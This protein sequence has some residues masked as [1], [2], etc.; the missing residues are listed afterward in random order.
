M[1][2]AI[3]FTNRSNISSK[4]SVFRGNLLEIRLPNSLS[5]SF[6]NASEQK[7]FLFLYSGIGDFVQKVSNF[8]NFTHYWI[9]ISYSAKNYTR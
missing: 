6:E 2:L 1:I 3:K 4:L 8:T 7:F 5:K 9:V